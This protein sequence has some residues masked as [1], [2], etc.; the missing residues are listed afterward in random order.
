M[1]PEAS[2]IWERVRERAGSFPP[3]AFAFVQAGLRHTV[4]TIKAAGEDARGEEGPD[5]ERHVTGQELCMGL[6]DLAVRQFGMLART[7]LRSWSIR[8]THDMGRVV[9]ILVESGVL[10]KSDRDSFADFDAVFDFEDAFDGVMKP[11]R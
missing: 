2:A 11:V 10:R 6:R 4:E 5:G 9:F 3:E 1:T 8:S 7:V